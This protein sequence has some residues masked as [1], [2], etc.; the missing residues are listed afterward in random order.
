MSEAYCSFFSVSEEP[1]AAPEAA[2]LLH[3]L[4]SRVLEVKMEVEVEVVV[5]VKVV[6]EVEVVVVAAA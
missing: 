3:L 5:E 1:G 6:I 4:P 2:L